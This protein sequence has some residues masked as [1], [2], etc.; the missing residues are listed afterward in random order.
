VARYGAVDSGAS[1]SEAAKAL[2]Y[3]L[4]FS[5]RREMVDQGLMDHKYGG[6]RERQPMKNLTLDI[7]APNRLLAAGVTVISV[8]KYHHGVLGM[9]TEQGFIP[10]AINRNVA[11]L[12]ITE[13]ANFMAA[14]EVD[15]VE[16]AANDE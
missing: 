7:T 11:A 14:E 9:E 12:L 10:I 3:S 6:L 15:P 13:L 8:E 16:Y 2:G 1:F 4:S 5:R